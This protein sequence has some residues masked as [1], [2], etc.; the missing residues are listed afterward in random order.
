MIGAIKW[1]K[2][3]LKHFEHTLRSAGIY[4]ACILLLLSFSCTWQAFCVLWGPLTNTLHHGAREVGIS[5]YDLERIDGL[6]I[7]GD[8][9]EEFLPRNKDLMDTKKFS[10][11]VLELLRIGAELCRFYKNS[12]SWK[13]GHQLAL[14]KS[15]KGSS[16]TLNIINIGELAAFLLSHF[17]LRYHNEVIRPKTFVMASSMAKGQNISLAPTVLGYI[18][19]GL[20][21]VI[22]HPNHPG[23]AIPYFLIHYVVAQARSIFRNRQSISFRAGAFWEQS[24]KGQDFVNMK[25]SDENI[26]F[27]LSI[28]S[29]VLPMR[30]GLELLVSLDLAKD[31]VLGVIIVERL[32]QTPFT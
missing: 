4:G 2:Y 29:S 24:P 5:F 25:L 19:H 3:I 30:I 10:P 23:R 1:T 8:V 18:Y 9:Y 32:D 12:H 27:L 22:S 13:K 31:F 14:H 15:R 20:G 6:P 21:E 28:R 11:I 16:S 26:K 17:V 7:L